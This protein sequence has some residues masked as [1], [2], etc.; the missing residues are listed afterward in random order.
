MQAVRAAPAPIAVP[1]GTPQPGMAEARAV[2]GDISVA[3]T[4]DDA[5]AEA[6][7]LGL[8]AGPSERSASAFNIGT[9][10]GDRTQAAAAMAQMAPTLRKGADGT[11]EIRLDPPELGRVRLTLRTDE[12]GLV[13][14][15]LAERPETMD[16]MRRNADMLMRDLMAGGQTKVDLSFGSLG[17]ETG[18]DGKKDDAPTVLVGFDQPGKAPGADLAT[19]LRLSRAAGGLDIRV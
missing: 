17:P 4:A 19:Q 2:D 12:T 10:A 14:T 6:D 15:V 18:G 1:Q 7:A 8:S 5:L 9:P 11:T 13:A 16:M 3:A